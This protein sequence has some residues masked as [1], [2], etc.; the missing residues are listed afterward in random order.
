MASVGA[1]DACVAET[2]VRGAD[3]AESEGDAIVN[4]A[5]AASGADDSGG[6]EDFETKGGG[7]RCAGS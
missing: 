7:V 2:S 4:S 6:G 1:G 3:S 5:D